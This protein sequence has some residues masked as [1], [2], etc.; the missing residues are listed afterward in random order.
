MPRINVKLDNVESGFETYPE[1]SYLVELQETTKIKKS[2]TS[3][4]PKITWISKILEGEFEDKLLSW[5]TSLQDQ[6][7]WNLKSMLEELDGVEWDE[8][9]FELDDCTYQKLIVDVIVKDWE[10]QPRNYVNGYHKA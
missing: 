7:L 9:G 6:A 8:D 10:G 3:G 2:K 4:E 1:D 5:D